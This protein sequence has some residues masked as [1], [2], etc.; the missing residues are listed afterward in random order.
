MAGEAGLTTIEVRPAGGASYPV[1]VGEGLLGE[2][3]ARVA[4]APTAVV[5]HPHALR[6]TAETVV[7]DLRGQ[8][9]VDAHAA[10]VPD[11]EEAKQLR[12]ADHLYQ[13]CA[14]VGLDRTGCVVGLGGGTVTD[15]AGF[16]AA[17]WMRGVRVVQVP[18]TL[19][20]M[21]D[22]AVGGKTGVN[23]A[24]GKNLVGAF[25]QPAAVVCDL[26]TLVTLPPEELS[27]GLAEVAKCGFIA[28]PRLLDLL[29]SDPTGR[30]RVR[31]LVEGSVR[32]KAEVVS[33]DPTEQG[34]REILNYGH[35]LG[36]ALERVERYSW[37]HGAAVSVGLVY[38]AALARRLGR[39]DAATAERHRR[40]LAALGLP[41]SY[42]GDRWE[43]L[44]EAMRVDKKSRG[45]H[46]RFV[47][48]SGLARPEVVEDPDPAELAAAYAELAG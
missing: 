47:L 1:L 11:G 21:V 32:V 13:V 45:G 26:A 17:T 46:L 22:A 31:E 39:L 3:T 15:L 27:A 9:G 33:A 5:V 34:R 42:R 41:V 4:P 30:T 36:H 38:A 2:V 35:T 20:G 14:R 6:A 18:T 24:A 40:L 29:E 19:V 28:D 23:T 25:H 10:E 7:A 8:G 48:L 12:Y 37:R 16:V 44:L 43:E